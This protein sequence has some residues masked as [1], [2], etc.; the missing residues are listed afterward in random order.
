MGRFKKIKSFTGSIAE[1]FVFFYPMDQAQIEQHY[2]DGLNELENGDGTFLMKELEKDEAEYNRQNFATEKKIPSSVLQEVEVSPGFFKTIKEEPTNSELN[3]RVDIH[4]EEVQTEG[5]SDEVEALQNLDAFI[6]ENPLLANEINEIANNFE[7]I[8]KAASIMATGDINKDGAL[9]LTRF[10]KI[11]KFCKINLQKSVVW[12][13]I[14]IT[15][16]GTEILCETDDTIKFKGV[17]YYYFLK[18]V[19]E[20]VFS[21]M[22]SHLADEEVEKVSVGHFSDSDDY[23]EEEEV[24]A[25]EE[26]GEPVEQEKPAAAGMRKD[27]FHSSPDKFSK[28]KNKEGEGDQSEE[29]DKNVDKTLDPVMPEDHPPIQPAKT[30]IDEP[31]LNEDGLIKNEQDQNFFHPEPE[32]EVDEEQE[33]EPIEEQDDES[34][35]ELDEDWNTGHFVV[36]II[37]CSGC[38]NHFDYCRHS[39][40]EYI[41][42]F[43]DMGND[44]IEKFPEAEIIGNH[45]RASYLGCFD[46]YLR[47]VGPM[48]KR[49]EQG[50]YFLFRKKL[51]GRMPKAKEITDILTIL[52]L[53]YGNS[54]KLGKAQQDFRKKYDYLI[55]K[56]SKEIHEHPAEVPSTVRK[57]PDLK[58]QAKPS[59]DRLMICKNWG[60]GREYNEEKNEKYA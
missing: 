43:N 24:E 16:T 6:F 7:W 34:L 1:L 40:D 21:D 46:I 58:K 52:S 5:N 13:M 26:K 54:E 51:A 18:I 44:I 10:M 22:M 47:G 53:L 45:E 60:C 23:V 56:P 32:P 28:F 9:E 31:S 4:D 3:D 38:H 59:G 42:A 11:L 15:K 57:Q 48:N 17:L 8:L 41:N 14:E 50:R 37:R 55:P 35:P 25:E 2:K 49:D 29:E 19:K 20:V 27:S 30:I 36:N 12:E 33:K 39:E